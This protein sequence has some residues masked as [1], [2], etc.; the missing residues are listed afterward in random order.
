MGGFKEIPIMEDV[1]LVGR[2]KKLG[3]LAI[4]KEPVITSS[5]RWEKEG[6][7]KT[8]I[9]NQILLFFFFLGIPPEK[10][11]RFYNIVR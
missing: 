3:K 1:E 8:T 11:Y 7:L 2:L 6:W 9:R 4:L 10:L 5:R